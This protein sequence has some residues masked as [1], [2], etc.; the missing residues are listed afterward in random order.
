MSQERAI[1]AGGCFWCM[2]QPF[3]EMSGILSVLSGYTGG[4]TPNPTYEAVLTHKTGH[5][6]AVEIIFDN[7]IVSYGE[8]VALYWTLTDPTDAFGQFQD[9]G[10][11]YRPVI[12]YDNGEQKRI[13]TDSKAQLQASGRFDFPIVV[14]IEPSQTFWPAESY[15]QGFYKTNPTRYAQSAQMRH[16]FL[17]RQWGKL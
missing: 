1:F 2:V 11:N 16:D 3:E 17:A 6:E 10:D 12:F 14:A 5:T 13:A 15:H 8:L 9:R 7:A 4:T